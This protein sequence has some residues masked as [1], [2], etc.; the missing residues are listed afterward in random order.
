MPKALEKLLVLALLLKRLLPAAML[1][2]MLPLMEPVYIVARPPLPTAN[3]P[4]PLKI[5][6]PPELMPA[7]LPLPACRTMADAD[8]L[9]V[10][11][12]WLTK[13]LADVAKLM[14]PLV[15]FMAPFTVKWLLAPV[16]E[17]ETLPVP[18]MVLKTVVA[19]DREKCRLALWVKDTEPE[20]RVPVVEPTS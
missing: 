9:V 10:E 15:R 4:L 16:M 13:R 1:R 8:A 17:A 20:P 14:V 12:L 3:A 11:R 19:V 7:A 5:T 6:S 18:V 2:P